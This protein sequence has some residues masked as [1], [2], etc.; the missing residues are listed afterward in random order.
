[1][2]P[3]PLKLE[4]IPPGEDAH[5]LRAGDVIFCHRKGLVSWMIRTGESIRGSHDW[6][7]VA[8]VEQPTVLIE[9][10]THGVSQS[11][12]SKYRH[13]RYGVVRI[14]YTGEDRFQALCFA[15]SC[16]GQRYGMSVIMGIALRY[17]TP[18]QGLWFGMNGTEICSGLAG[19]MLVRGWYNFKV[20]PASITPTELCSELTG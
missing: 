16:I 19:Q 9:A 17:L 15:Q 13:I 10:L 7:H 6:S 1:M 3:S 18:G 8:V 14:P 5:G 4:I 20:N 11:P 12:L 2:R